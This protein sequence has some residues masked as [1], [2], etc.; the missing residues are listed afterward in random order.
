M[1]K[2]KKEAKKSKRKL[3]INEER[4]NLFVLFFVSE[5]HAH[6]IK[7]ESYQKKIPPARNI[8]EKKNIHV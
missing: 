3:F 8:M 7:R 4:G 1:R 5:R 6:S 2:E